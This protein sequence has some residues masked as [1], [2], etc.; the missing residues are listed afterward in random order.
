MNS[1]EEFHAIKNRA[2]LTKQLVDDST[3]KT[4]Q[5]GSG[6]ESESERVYSNSKP[7][8]QPVYCLPTDTIDDDDNNNGKTKANVIA[9]KLSTIQR[10]KL[11]E[12]YEV[13]LLV[14]IFIFLDILFS[15]LSLVLAVESD[16]QLLSGS[17]RIS[18]LRVFHS[19][20]S[21]CFSSCL[22]LLH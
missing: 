21:F 2:R 3:I 4:E 22:K 20:T 15:T 16:E 10:R 17:T 13:Q 1:F 12:L 19:F 6:S 14:C 5:D 9:G 8:E 18:L 7:V 11:M